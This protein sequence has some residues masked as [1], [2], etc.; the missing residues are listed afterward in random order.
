MFK[1]SPAGALHSAGKLPGEG[2]GRAPFAGQV[3]DR[4]GGKLIASF[5]DPPGRGQQVFPQRLECQLLSQE[6]ATE[7]PM[8]RRG[9]ERC[10]EPEKGE[11]DAR[12]AYSNPEYEIQVAPSEHQGLVEQVIEI[13][14]GC[15]LWVTGLQGEFFFIGLVEILRES[16]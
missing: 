14:Q 4:D 2:G 10:H 12:R 7:N 9:E 5:T 13:A 16:T 11:A 15:A 3:A 8:M 1:S 6:V